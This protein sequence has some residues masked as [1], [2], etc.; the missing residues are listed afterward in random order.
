MS[1]PQTLM[2]KGY[3]NCKSL[4]LILINYGLYVYTHGET[5]DSIK[6]NPE[7]R[8]YDLLISPKLLSVDE[9][10]FCHLATISGTEIVEVVKP[11]KEIE[12]C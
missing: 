9:K 2:L 10:H 8:E 5:T 12:Q 1:T 3:S 7:T 11:I 6:Q 4:A